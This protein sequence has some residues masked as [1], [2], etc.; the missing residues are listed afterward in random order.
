M[1][2]SNFT[3]E[4]NEFLDNAKARGVTEAGQLAILLREFQ[5]KQRT[6]SQLPDA[7]IPDL[8]KMGGGTTTVEPKNTENKSGTEQN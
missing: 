4:E 7:T 8:P 3:P 5:M 2:D 1:A 6:S